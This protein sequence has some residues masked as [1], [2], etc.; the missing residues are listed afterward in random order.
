MFLISL[1]NFVICLGGF[2]LPRPWLW[3]TLIPTEGFPTLDPLETLVGDVLNMKLGNCVL[4][5]VRTFLHDSARIVLISLRIVSASFTEV[6]Q[7]LVR[8][9]ISQ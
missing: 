8:S 6:A 7:A 2:A 3:E 1:T 9:F 4:A 5:D